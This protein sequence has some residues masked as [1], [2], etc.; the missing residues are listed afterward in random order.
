MRQQMPQ[1]QVYRQPQQAYIPAPV[2]QNPGRGRGNGR[3]KQEQ[4]IYAAPVQRQIPFSPGWVPPGQIRS[5]EV[6]ERNAIRKAQQEQER[7]FR[8]SQ[9]YSQPYYPTY[10]QPSQS[11]RE[12]YSGQYGYTQPYTQPYY[13]P[14]YQYIAPAYVEPYQYTGGGYLVNSPLYLP[15]MYVYEPYTAY[16]YYPDYYGYASPIYGYD[17]G[18]LSWKSMLLRTLIGFVF[19]GGGNDYYAAQPYEPYYSNYDYYT[20]ASYGYDNYASYAGYYPATYSSQTYYSEP[21]YDYSSYDDPLINTIPIDELVGV[22]YGGYSS[23]LL[24]DVLAQG[25]EQGYYAGRYSR[26][27]RHSRH[28]LSRVY[29]RYD[30]YFDP[31]SSTVSQDR[32]VFAEGYNLGYQDALAGRRDYVAGFGRNSNLFSLLLSNVIGLG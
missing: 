24:R 27:R 30:E 25:Y 2:Y 13:Y 11:Y 19:G 3:A 23:Q 7:A 5:A 21:V 12:Q 20:P 18:S 10:V 15:N 31:Y 6:H 29:S 8:Q 14:N 17:S 22:G 9:R 1:Q 28:Y 26:G 32:R 16:T 4:R